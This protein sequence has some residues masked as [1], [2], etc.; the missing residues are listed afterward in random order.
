MD[1]DGVLNPFPDCPE[2]FR[3]YDFFPNNDEPVRLAPA[4]GDWLKE[5]AAVFEIAWASGWG[6][7][8]NRFICAL[9]DL[10]Q[11]PV[12]VF[13]STPFEPREKVPAVASFVGDRPAAWVDDNVTTEAR[14]WAKERIIPTLLLEVDSAT[15]LTRPHVDE[16]LG[17]AAANAPRVTVPR[18]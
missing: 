5:L 1:V 8:A 6:A 12:V 4:H 2:G 18:A 17:W 15:G 3:E 11:F 9:F 13:P 16:L 7:E 14:G 10:P